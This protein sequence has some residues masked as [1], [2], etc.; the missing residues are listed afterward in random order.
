[1]AARRLKTPGNI[2]P[3]I[4]T[5]RGLNVGSRIR[6]ADNSGAKKV[7]IIAVKG[8]KG[9]RRRRPKATVGDMVVVSV[10]E[11]TPDLRK[12]V[13]KAVITTMRK[14]FV[15]PSGIRVEFEE[16]T[17]VLVDDEG[18]VRGSEVKSVVAKEAIIR[19]PSIGKIARMV[20]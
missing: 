4:R 20:V 5:I 15:R 18:K 19:W 14:E 8:Y 10:K 11:G 16:N 12:K 1:M 13:A 17:C 9:I 6:C 3:H 7:E 2:A